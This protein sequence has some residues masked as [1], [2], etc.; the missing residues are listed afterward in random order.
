MRQVR[1]Q[2]CLS[3]SHFA[4]WLPLCGFP[5]PHARAVLANSKYMMSCSWLGLCNILC[6]HH[7]HVC[8]GSCFVFSLLMCLCAQSWH[9]KNLI[10]SAV[11]RH[12]WL[13]SNC[14][15]LKFVNPSYSSTPHQ[16]PPVVSAY[17]LANLGLRIVC[18]V[19]SVNFLDWVII[20]FSCV[21]VH[22]ALRLSSAPLNQL[23]SQPT[24]VCRALSQPAHIANSPRLAHS[25]MSL[26]CLYHS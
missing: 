7:S 26:F 11:S 21:P 8:C 16:P 25:L 5:C 1:I 17:T 14:H 9:S 24:S 19:S 4:F 6:V 12:T 22:Q 10:W 15:A 3:W 23:H 13:L 2:G 18:L 20:L